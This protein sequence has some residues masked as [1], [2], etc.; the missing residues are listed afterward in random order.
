[1]GERRVERRLRVGAKQF[2]RWIRSLSEVGQLEL[3]GRYAL[4]APFVDVGGRERRSP[5]CDE[6]SRNAPGI[7]VH[8]LERLDF[9]PGDIAEIRDP[10]TALQRGVVLF[11]FIA[12]VLA[13]ARTVSRGLGASSLGE[14][15][16]T[17]S[18]GCHRA[19]RWT[20]SPSEFVDSRTVTPSWARSIKRIANSPDS[21]LSSVAVRR[22]AIAWRSDRRGVSPRPAQ[23]VR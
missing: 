2:D 14:T 8:D 4:R 21:V 17:A 15:L 9:R 23:L 16:K 7:L 13:R 6:V 22:A 10:D 11:A 18:V 12:V 19:E 3:I 20:D 5:I 1:M